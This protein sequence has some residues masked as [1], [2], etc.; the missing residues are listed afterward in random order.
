MNRFNVDNSRTVI[1]EG[2]AMRL[3]A[4]IHRDNGRDFSVNDASNFFLGVAVVGESKAICLTLIRDGRAE[5]IGLNMCLT[6]DDARQMRDALGDNVDGL[7]AD[8]AR[9]AI[10][11]IL[12]AGG[13]PG[14]NFSETVDAVSLDAL[15]RAGRGASPPFG[16][17]P[18]HSRSAWMLA[19]IAI[20]WLGLQGWALWGALS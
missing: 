18:G 9:Q 4:H 17:A 15:D 12:A 7:E 16:A 8:A 13:K 1:A 6:V 14:P 10:D 19:G 11:T 20:G 2:G 3:G 5:A